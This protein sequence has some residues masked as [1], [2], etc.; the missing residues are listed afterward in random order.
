MDVW[1]RLPAILLGLF[2]A[3]WLVRG[4]R[5]LRRRQVAHRLANQERDSVLLETGD[6]K[7]E[8]K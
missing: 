4:L 3:R 5:E 2:V 1:G 7:L 8:P 6:E